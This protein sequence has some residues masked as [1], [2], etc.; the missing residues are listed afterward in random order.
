MGLEFLILGPLE[1]RRAGLPLDLG[2]PKRRTL[3]ATLVVHA[4]EVVSFER[5][6]ECL[7]DGEAP[8]TARAVLQNHVHGLRELLGADRLDRVGH[9]YRLAVMDDELDAARF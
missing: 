9:G 4:N 2:P 7:W 1:V 8:A 6:V 3:L 5:L